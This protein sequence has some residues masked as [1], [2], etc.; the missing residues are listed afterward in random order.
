LYLI[1]LSID[2][3]PEQTKQFNQESGE[4]VVED[5][6]T[7]TEDTTGDAAA[8]DITDQDANIDA[9]F[10]YEEPGYATVNWPKGTVI[11]YETPGTL[12]LRND[13]PTPSPI[14][15]TPPESPITSIPIDADVCV[16]AAATDAESSS[17]EGTGE[18]KQPGLTD[19]E[20][21]K[22][23]VMDSESPA[24]HASSSP[25]GVSTTS[26]VTGTTHGVNEATGSFHY[27]TGWIASAN[28][29]VRY[30]MNI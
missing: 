16:K 27:K 20:Q 23:N 18:D 14:P 19:G 9:L 7:I 1:F 21:G 10:D 5:S 2:M 6:V 3:E 29:K 4:Q 25:G 12:L 26:G 13:V 28:V 8:S 22:E 30:A 15:I 17:Q 11:F 24:V